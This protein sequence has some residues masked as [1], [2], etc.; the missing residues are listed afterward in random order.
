M[1]A[2]PNPVLFSELQ[3]QL[4][5]ESIAD[6]IAALHDLP[7]LAVPILAGGFIFAADLL[8]ALERRDVA[9]P[10]EFIWL[11]SY[12]GARVAQAEVRVLAGPG[13]ITEGRH[14]LVIDGV[15]DSGNTLG[16]AREILVTAGARRVTTVVAVDKRRADAAVTADFAGFAGVSDFIAG[17]GMDDGGG[18]RALP[19]IVRST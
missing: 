6:E 8:R 1:S 4:R 16:K 10:V 5:V 17:Y 11:R 14:A 15:L 3:I 12:A 7:D 2:Q 13:E 18:K 19:H 9:M